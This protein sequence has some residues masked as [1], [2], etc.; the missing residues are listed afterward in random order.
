MQKKSQIKADSKLNPQPEPPRPEAKLEHVGINPQPEP[1]KPGDKLQR[2]GLN[3]QPE[4]PSPKTKLEKVGL[5]PQ[6]EPPSPKTKLDRVGLNPQPEPPASISKFKAIKVF[7]FL[8]AIGFGIVGF[9]FLGTQ[10]LP[11]IELAQTTSPIGDA[12]AI[13]QAAVNA[14][15]LPTLATLIPA[16]ALLVTGIVVKA[17]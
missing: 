11:A 6:P 2:V 16:G 14:S 10:L 13:A 17:R 12:Y 5:N 7:A 8:G 3:P 15:L 9:Y 4:P 1:P